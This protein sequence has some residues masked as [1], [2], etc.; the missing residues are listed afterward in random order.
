MDITGSVALVTGANR[1]LGRH[2]AQQLLERGAAKVY[3]TSRRPEL[4]DV[5]GV[6]VLRLD[7]TDPG[8]IAAAAAAA[9]DVTLLV[10]NAGLTT[11]ADLVTGDLA[12]VRL[13]ME[14]HF[15]GTLGVIRAFAPVLARNGG[16]AIA[17]VLSALSWFST[18]GANA[19]SAAKAAE[20]SLT[21]GVRIELTEQ[22]TAV[23]GV[24]LG[25]ADT[26]MMAGYTGPMSDPADVVRAALDGVQA[27]E[28]EVLVDDWSRG[29]KAAL[30]ADPR[31]FYG[32]LAI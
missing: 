32:Q 25:A 27:G 1:G 16:G 6:E 20:W 17:N 3:A 14:T 13:E 5:P 15:F 11:R 10:N 2:F 18:A 23:T 12:D 30:S 8:S 4:V 21:N 24:V 26:D 28:W 7:V 22:G 19:Y 9:G 31:E 29:V